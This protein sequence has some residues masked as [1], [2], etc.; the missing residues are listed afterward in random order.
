MMTMIKQ[1]NEEEQEGAGGSMMR[2]KMRY[3][4]LPFRYISV[5]FK[6]CYIGRRVCKGHT[7]KMEMFGPISCPL[8]SN[9]IRIIL[10]ESAYCK[11]FLSFN[12]KNRELIQ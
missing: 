3:Y 11:D 10:E 6:S 4:Y 2:K 1:D 7:S 8:S 12:Q 5:C 9:A